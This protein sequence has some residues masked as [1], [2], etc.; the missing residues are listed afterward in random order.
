[1]VFV[2]RTALGAQ[3]AQVVRLI[4]GKGMRMVLAGAAVGIAGGFPVAREPAVRRGAARRRHVDRGAGDPAVGGVGGRMAAGSEGVAARSDGGAA[5]GVGA[6]LPV[7]CHGNCPDSSA[8]GISTLPPKLTR[9][10]GVGV[11]RDLH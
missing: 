3:P 5:D 7:V 6:E 1:M 8:P 10:A 11:Q 4:V 9:E 2:V